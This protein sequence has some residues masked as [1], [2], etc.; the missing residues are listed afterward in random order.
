MFLC[1]KFHQKGLG[2]VE[3]TES[4]AQ[5]DDS[6]IAYAHIFKWGH[7]KPQFTGARYS[8][9]FGDVFLHFLYARLRV[10]SPA[11]CFHPSL[12]KP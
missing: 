3:N 6:G 8:A 10:V 11:C 2:G 1:A 5:R 12:S 9:N 7:I 4:K